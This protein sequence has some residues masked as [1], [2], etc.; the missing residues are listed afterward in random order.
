[1]V[2]AGQKS[3]ANAK[4]KAE[5]LEPVEAVKQKQ[6]SKRKKMGDGSRGELKKRK[7]NESQ[8]VNESGKSRRAAPPR[9]RLGFLLHDLETRRRTEAS[10]RVGLDGDGPSRYRS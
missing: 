4:R 9:T 8:L 2:C 6:T 1:M 10:N 7:G 5:A 3:G